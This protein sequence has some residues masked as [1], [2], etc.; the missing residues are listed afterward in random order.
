MA[1]GAARRIAEA[2]PEDER[3]K[4][5]CEYRFFV[6][7]VSCKGVEAYEKL[8][9][10]AEM[11]SAFQIAMKGDP[12]E[13]GAAPWVALATA[14]KERKGG[15][16][17]GPAVAIVGA[18]RDETYEAAALCAVKIFECGAQTPSADQLKELLALCHTAAARCPLD[19]KK[20]ES[21]IAARIVEESAAT[22]RELGAATD[23]VD[24]LATVL[25][26]ISVWQPLL[27]T[28]TDPQLSEES[29]ADVM[30]NLNAMRSHY[31]S[32]VI[33]AITAAE[34]ER[35]ECLSHK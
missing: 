19:V 7:G 20:L 9:A 16:S 22:A 13:H 10:T 24:G 35:M 14:C 3:L 27:D 1:R 21:A 18:S 28:E 15:L 25:G 34:R 12:S 30:A 4:D 8:V 33:T 29:L 6:G 31:A 11:C 23:D 32:N 5:G 17:K 26:R 2:D